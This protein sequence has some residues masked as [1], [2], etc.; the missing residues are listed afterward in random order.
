MA[1]ATKSKQ[2]SKVARNRAA[3][4]EPRKDTPMWLPEGTWQRIAEKAYELYEQRG[5]RE[6]CAL[7]DWLDAEKLVLGE[8]IE[9]R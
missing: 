4:G 3:H 9:A 2:Q 8:F 7:E 1:V 5:R 6:S